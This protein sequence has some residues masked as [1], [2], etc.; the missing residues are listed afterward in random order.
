[1]SI[2]AKFFIFKKFSYSEG[3]RETPI[4]LH[5]TV[6]LPT[7]NS[8]REIC[9]TYDLKI[10]TID[11]E[12]L[13]TFDDFVTALRTVLMSAMTFP[14]RQKAM[15]FLADRYVF[16]KESSGCG[17]KLDGSYDWVSWDMLYLDSPDV[18]VIRINENT[19][20]LELDKN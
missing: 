16:D 4:S 10:P 15:E 7:I 12:G 11:L 14:N 8:I 20:S 2:N 6:E 3:L 5:G 18:I 1:M 13:A 17:I 9:Q 19:V